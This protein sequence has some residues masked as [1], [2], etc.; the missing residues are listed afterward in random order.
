MRDPDYRAY[1]EWIAQHGLFARIRQ[2]F[3]GRQA[4]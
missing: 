3:G 4:G 2:A 1:A